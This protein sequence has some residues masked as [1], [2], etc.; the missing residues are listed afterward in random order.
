MQLPRLVR[1][2]LYDERWLVILVMIILSV[3][4]IGLIGIMIFY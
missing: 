2:L 1:N 4:V 3:H